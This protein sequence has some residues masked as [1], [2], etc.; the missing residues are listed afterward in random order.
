MPDLEGRPDAVAL[1]DFV[2]EEDSES[3]VDGLTLTEPELDA[4]PET[5]AEPDP[6]EETVIDPVGGFVAVRVSC[7]VDV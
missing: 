6:E 3:L 4:E 1:A 5:D 7:G 2:V